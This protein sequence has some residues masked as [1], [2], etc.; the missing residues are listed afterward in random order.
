LARVT[1]LT[2]LAAAVSHQL[3]QPLTAIRTNADAGALLLARTPPDV[4][5]ARQALQEIA[6][7]DA[8]ASEI[9]EHFR[10]H[11]R[12]HDPI[13]TT[14]DLNAVCQQIAKLMA[15]E[16]SDRQARLVLRLDPDVPPIRGDPVQLQQALIN[17][18][19]N[20]LDALSDWAP[21]REATISTVTHNGGVELRVSDT[22][23][24]LSPDVHQRLF[25]PFFSTKPHG[26]GMGLTIVR[27]IVERH[28]GFVRAENRSAGGA[29]FTVTLP[30][31]E[32][33]ARG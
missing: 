4:D 7:D 15:R 30:G 6:R 18:T 20:A 1:T 32:V 9:I 2:G 3:R 25:E 8:R 13:S 14:V 26:V 28:H 11:F 12:K 21:V 33:R 22:G 17:L 31:G 23:P 5:E 19:L 29:L 16:V 10:A 24:G 27:S